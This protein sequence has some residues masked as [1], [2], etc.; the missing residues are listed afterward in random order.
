MRLPVLSLAFFASSAAVLCAQ[1]QLPADVDPQSLSRLPFPKKADMDPE[2]LRIF[3]SLNGKDAT[4]PRTAPGAAVLYSPLLAEPFEHLNQAARKVSVGPRYFELSA[5]MGARAF[6]QQYEWSGHE[7]AARRAGVEQ[8]VIDAIKFNRPLDGLP[9][10]DATLIRFGR[11]LFQQHKVDAT[12]YAKVVEQFGKQGMVECAI[13]MGDY[14]MAGVLL[15]AVDQQLPAD[16][17][18]LLP[19]K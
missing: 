3:E 1:P 13:I 17:K 16:R 19:E 2:G 15:T 14:A 9:E 10:K 5:L 12:L 18:P 8:S 7:L 11:A 4:T 6:D